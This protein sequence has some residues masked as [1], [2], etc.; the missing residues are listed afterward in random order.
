MLLNNG[1]N[2]NHDD[3]VNGPPIILATHRCN[4]DIVELLLQFNA[5]PNIY[6]GKGETCLHIATNLGAVEIVRILLK[7]HANPNIVDNNLNTPLNIASHIVRLVV[8]ITSKTWKNSV[9]LGWRNHFI[10]YRVRWLRQALTEIVKLLLQ[11]RA[12]PLSVV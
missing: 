7:Y 10:S 4:Y 1:A 6:N 5:T 8:F 3:D 2:P 12:D 9:N 11:N